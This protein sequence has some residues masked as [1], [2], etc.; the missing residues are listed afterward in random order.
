MR[1]FLMMLWGAFV[2]S[3]IRGGVYKAF[4]KELPFSMRGVNA[5]IYGATALMMTMD[6]KLGL[7]CAIGMYIGSLFDIGSRVKKLIDQE[8]DAMYYMM[9]RGFIWVIPLMLPICLFGYK[10][11]FFWYLPAL[12]GMGLCYGLPHMSFR[13]YPQ[14]S[15]KWFHALSVSEALY[16]TLLFL[17]LVH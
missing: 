4:F 14:L 6:F 17:P 16:G 9:E 3:F 11:M 15:N 12:L 13:K 7:L 10:N 1:I 8:P 2:N 5:L